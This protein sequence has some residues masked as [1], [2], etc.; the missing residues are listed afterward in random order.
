MQDEQKTAIKGWAPEDRP[1]EKLRSMGAGSLSD[2]E[3]LAILIQNGTRERSALDLGKELMIKSKNNLVEL[4]RLS[5]RE[6]MKI[7][8]IGMAKAISIAAALEL[9]RRR[10]ATESLDKP[11]VTSSSSVARFLQ[12]RF[13]DLPHEIFAV[14]FLNRANKII[15]FEIVSSGGITGTVADPRIILKKALEEEA[16][17]LILC[18]NH[19]SGSLKPSRAD[20]ELTLKIKEASRFFDIKVLDHVIVSSE[21]YFSFADEGLI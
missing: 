15:H 18:H 19:P 11:L 10:L 9:G 12:A 16:V 7:R 1:R 17:S 5:I 21:G 8:G 2:A 13:R 14:V 4:G 20:E 6:L 3:L